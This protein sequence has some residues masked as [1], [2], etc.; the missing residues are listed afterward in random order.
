MFIG[1]RNWFAKDWEEIFYSSYE[2]TSSIK[3]PIGIHN[4]FFE[5]KKKVRKTHV[6]IW[7]VL[8]D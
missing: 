8:D 5:E 7:F 1:I 3:I 6:K 2:A 4:I